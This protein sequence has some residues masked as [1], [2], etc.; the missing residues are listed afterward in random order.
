[1]KTTIKS[2]AEKF[3]R[4]NLES[5]VVILNDPTAFPEGSGGRLWAEA[6]VRRLE[7]DQERAVGRL[8]EQ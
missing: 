2:V 7:R 1:M 8:F 6:F 5:A 3:N 4:D